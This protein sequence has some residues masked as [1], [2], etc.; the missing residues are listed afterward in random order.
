MDKTSDR[1]NYWNRIDNYDIGGEAEPYVSGP[2]AKF[3]RQH[4]RGRPVLV[5]FGCWG[6]RHLA[7]LRE[8]AGS[9]GRVV[10]T[11]GPWAWER[12]TEAR[13]LVN[14]TPGLNAEIQQQRLENLDRFETESV[15]GALCWR[16]LHNRT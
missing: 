6:G 11:D 5:D 7:L 16:V 2:G 14:D 9:G 1:T 4:L 8:L 10:G 3:F 15:D 12:L 13:D